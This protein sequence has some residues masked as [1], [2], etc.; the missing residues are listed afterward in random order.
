MKLHRL[1]AAFALAACATCAQAQEW[2]AKPIHFILGPSPDLLPRLIGA[3]F[4]EATGQPVVIDQRPGAGGIIAGE[5]VAKSPA[6]GYTWMQSSASFVI[7]ATFTPGVSFKLMNDFTPV[8]LMATI[9]FVLVVN[10]SVPAKTTAELVALAKAQPGK[11]NYA[12]S[13][14]GGSAHLVGE[15]F[16][17]YAHINMVHVPYK[18]VAAAVTDLIGG[19]VQLSFIVAQ[20][21]LPF[22]AN[23]K[24][25]ALGVTSLK[26]SLSAPELPTIAEQGFPGF[27]MIGWNGIHVPAKTPRPVIDKINAVVNHALHDPALRATMLKAGLEPADTSPADFDAFVKRDVARY[28]KVV[29]ESNIKFE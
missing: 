8:T 24:L 19:Q 14:N 5:A 15:M 29:K 12:S 1:A 3:K 26:R 23:G 6:D 20:A 17:N 10:P 25:R 18:G 7:T 9:P 2:P 16:K 22:V 11:L 27:E 28:T 4:T 21:A 13:G